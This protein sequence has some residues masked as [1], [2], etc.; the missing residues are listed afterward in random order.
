MVLGASLV[1][2]PKGDDWL[3]EPKWDGF[4]FQVIK[5]G[6]EVRLYSKSGALE[7]QFKYRLPVI[8]SNDYPPAAV[9]RP[10]QGFPIYEPLRAF[11]CLHFGVH[12]IGEFDAVMV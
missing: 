1:H 7:R 12:S 3:H 2:P 5:D 11:Y 4:R 8:V 6:S 9:R 10:V